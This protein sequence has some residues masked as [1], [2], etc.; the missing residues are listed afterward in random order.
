MALVDEFSN[1]HK[2]EERG[3]VDVD[4][5]DAELPRPRHVEAAVATALL[6]AAVATALLQAAVATA[7]LYANDLRKNREDR[8]EGERDETGRT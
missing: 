8:R 1:K 6:K 5:D 2:K 4:A 3:R 7:L